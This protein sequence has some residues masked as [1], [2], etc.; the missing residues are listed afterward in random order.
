MRFRRVRRACRVIGV[1]AFAAASA[2]LPSI[3]SAAAYGNETAATGRPI[4]ADGTTYIDQMTPTST[5]SWFVFRLEPNQSYSIEVSNP[6]GKFG[7]IQNAVGFVTLFEADGTTFVPTTTRS[8]DFPASQ[9]DAGATQGGRITLVNEASS[10]RRVALK[11]QQNGGPPSTPRDFA[12]RVVPTTL[13]APRWSVNGYDAF[14]ALTNTIFSGEGFSSV[15][16]K[17]LY[18]NEAGTLVRSDSFSLAS[19][20]STQIVKPNGVAIGGAVRGGVRI[21]HKGAPGA[22]LAHQTL[23]SP[24]TGQ[25]IQYPVVPLA[26][27]YSRGGI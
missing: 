6:F 12:V 20:A 23:F 11:A 4:M 19:N 5:V 9:A 26:H 15:T 25:F 3:A 17:I 27:A 16:G 18:Y 14:F 7:D 13:I 21:I 2:V 10:A 8:F 1:M 22:I 24:G